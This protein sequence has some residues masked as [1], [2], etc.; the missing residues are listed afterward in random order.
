MDSTGTWKERILALAMGWYSWPALMI[1][2]RSIWPEWKPRPPR[3]PGGAF[4]RGKNAWSAVFADDA[5]YAS[6]M[7]CFTFDMGVI[8]ICL[9]AL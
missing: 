4:H 5:E 9:T 7:Y 3:E 1:Q 6:K 2:R 8:L